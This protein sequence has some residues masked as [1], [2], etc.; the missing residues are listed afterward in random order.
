MKSFD[1]TFKDSYHVEDATSMSTATNRLKAILDAKYEAADLKAV[2]DEATHLSQDER[3]KLLLLLQKYKSLFDGTLGKGTGSPYNIELKEGAQP[4]HAKPFPIPRAHV[5]TLR[6]EVE[7]L[8]S[9]GVLKRV[10]QSEW[11]ALTFVIPKKNKTNCL[12]F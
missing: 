9:L 3:D 4:Y 1:T 12:R 10:N 5:D 8:C 11:G 2:V 6:V 7:R